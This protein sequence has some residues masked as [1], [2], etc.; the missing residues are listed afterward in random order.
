[1]CNFKQYFWFYLSVSSPAT[2]LTTHWVLLRASSTI[3]LKVALYI[4]LWK[5]ET[6][7]RHSD[8]LSRKNGLVT[9]CS[10]VLSVTRSKRKWPE[11][12]KQNCQ[13]RKYISFFSSVNYHV[14]GLQI[15]YLYCKLFTRCDY[16][17]HILNTTKINKPFTKNVYNYKT[18]LQT[19]V[20]R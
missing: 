18:K 7:S 12:T 3:S 9:D 13:V 2:S 20:P 8:G 10:G 16:E 17:I 6:L 15:S 14:Y 11:I 5:S 1:M 4:P 19:A